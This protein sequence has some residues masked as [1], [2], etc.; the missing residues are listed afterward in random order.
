MA[1]LKAE[2]TA[3]KGKII[4]APKISTINNM[5]AEIQIRQNIPLFLTNIVSTGQGSVVSGT[6]VTYRPVD[7]G[8]SVLPRINGDDSVT[9]FIRPTV[10]DTGRDY[11]SGDPTNPQTVPEERTQFLQTNRRVMNG[12]TIVLGGFVRREDTSEVH[13]VPILGD[14]PLIGG[15]FR[16]KTSD[17]QDRE[18]LIFLTPTIIP[19]RGGS[20]T[21]VRPAL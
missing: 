3:G 2:L 20:A 13:K 14:L 4:N 10:S 6:T 18:L 16:N 15:L 12:E 19:E 8:L 11:T 7:T 21:G 17:A 9:M 1:Q 5:W